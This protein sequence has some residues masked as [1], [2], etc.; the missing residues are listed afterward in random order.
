MEAQHLFCANRNR[1]MVTGNLL[2]WKVLLVL[3]FRCLFSE[4]TALHRRFLHYDVFMWVYVQ[5][6]VSA[7]QKS[8]C[9]LPLE[10]SMQSLLKFTAITQTKAAPGSCWQ[11]R[12][13]YAFRVL[14]HPGG[15]LH[16]RGTGNHHRHGRPCSS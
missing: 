6:A 11:C 4:F 3:T 7:S 14:E 15:L 2:I 8:H 5:T 10:V 1:G 9:P 13:T 12:G 16:V